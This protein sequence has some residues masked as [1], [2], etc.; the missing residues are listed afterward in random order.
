MGILKVIADDIE[1]LVDMGYDDKEIS[2]SV[3]MDK[4]IIQYMIDYVRNQKRNIEN[5]NRK[6]INNR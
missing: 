1:H 6:N 4:N 5:N 2:V 3:G